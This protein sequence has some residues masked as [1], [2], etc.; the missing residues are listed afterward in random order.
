MRKKDKAEQ[1]RE[2]GRALAYRKLRESIVSLEL[3]PGESI[4]ETATVEMLGVSRTPVREALIRLASEG[5]VEQLPNRS[6]RVTSMNVSEVRDH[7]EVF[8]LIQRTATHWAAI[9]RTE[10]DIKKIRDYRYAFEDFVRVNDVNAMIEAN[11]EFHLAIGEATHSSRLYKIYN[12][13]LVEGLR[14]ARLAMAYE[15]FST[16]QQRK[17]HL[18]KIIEEHEQLERLIRDK[19][20]EEAERVAARH[21]DLAR[22]RVIEY[23]ER[24]LAA[25]IKDVKPDMGI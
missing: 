16:S 15:H 21:S 5:L 18:D 6:T 13:L 25:S 14:I 10:D 8:G 7:L 23:L 1:P 9:N 24:D 11:L 22:N 20:A 4:D 3:K 19:N 12:G 17:Q 2:S